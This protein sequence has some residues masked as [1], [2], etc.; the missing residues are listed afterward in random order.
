MNGPIAFGSVKASVVRTAAST[1]LVKNQCRENVRMLFFTCSTTTNKKET[2]IKC[3]ERRTCVSIKVTIR[4]VAR[5][6]LT[7]KTIRSGAFL[8][9]HVVRGATLSLLPSTV[10]DVVV[11][12]A[13][14]NLGEILHITQDTVTVASLNALMAVATTLVKFS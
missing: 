11:H 1:F 9:K 3:M 10:N 4:R 8:R 6:P 5:H 13:P 7:R 2:Y 14:L 12:H